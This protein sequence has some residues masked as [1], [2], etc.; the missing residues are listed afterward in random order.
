MRLTEAQARFIR[1][2]ICAAM[3]NGTRIWLFGSRVDDNRRGGD[4]D[5]YVEPAQPVSLADELRVRSDIADRLDLE[6]DL[7]VACQEPGSQPIHRI[8]RHTGVPL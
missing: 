7:I 2:R 6:V 5:L 3:G 4:V 8:A 1:E